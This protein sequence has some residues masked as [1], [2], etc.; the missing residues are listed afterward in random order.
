MNQKEEC[1]ELF[2]NMMNAVHY[3]L[4]KNK[5]FYPIGA[6]ML[7]NGIIQLTAIESETD[8]PDSNEVIKQLISLHHKKAIEKE[9]T[10]SAIA[11]NATVR[12]EEADED[13][14]IVSLE[15]IDGYS[16]QVVVP[17]KFGLL[18]KIKYGE[19]FA[20]QQIPEVFNK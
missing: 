14:I 15:H 19:V 9:I 11:Y 17:Y 6:V 16:V 13:A 4:N 18:N 5:E 7:S 10:A 8:H 2:D 1:D 12:L 20:Q 3:L